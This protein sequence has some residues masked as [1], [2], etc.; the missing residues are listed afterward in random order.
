MS[1]L[2]KVLI[3]VVPAVV[4]INGVMGYYVWRAIRD[5]ENYRVDPPLKI[6]LK[7]K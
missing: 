6:K 5:P 2:T 3:A 4:W 7:V 1:E